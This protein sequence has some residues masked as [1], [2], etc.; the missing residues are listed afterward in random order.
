M[1]FPPDTIA[2]GDSV[3]LTIEALNRSGTVIPGAAVFLLSLTPDTLG[4][5]LDSVSVIGVAPGPGIAQAGIGNLRSTPFPI[6]VR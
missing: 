6:V 5:G 4:I 2:V 3:P 1:V